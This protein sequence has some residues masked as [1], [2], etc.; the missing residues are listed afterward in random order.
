MHSTLI[1]LALTLIAS[2]SPGEPPAS[3]PATLTEARAAIKSEIQDRAPKGDGSKPDAPPKGVFDLI[4]Y[5]SPAGDLAAYLSPDPKDGKKHPAIIVCTGGFGG[6][7]SSSWTVER[8]T[9]HFRKAGLIVMCPSWRGQQSNPGR[10][11]CFRGEIDDALAALEHLRALPYVDTSRIYITGHSTGGTVSLMVAE[12]TDKVRA[13]FPLGARYDARELVQKDE[14]WDMPAPFDVNNAEELRIRSPINFI[15][16]IQASTFAFEGKRSPNDVDAPKANQLAK[17]AGK[18]FTAFS[19]TSGDHFNIVD[20]INAL[21]AAKIAADTGPA[22]SIAFSDEEVQRAFATRRMPYTPR[23]NLDPKA[24]YLRMT[25]AAVEEIASAMKE[26]K[27]DP[28]KVYVRFGM[29]GYF[30]YHI[31][32]DEEVDPR[33]LTIDMKQFKVLLDPLSAF[34]MR[35]TAISYSKDG[36]FDYENP[37]EN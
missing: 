17:A 27:H 9:G 6:I 15:A 2:A 5:K 24:P 12:C 37:N 31:S 25:N 11:E 33:D 18:P 32:F 29:D 26:R 19:I 14:I 22:L 16:T 3:S 30:S 13:A 35:G 4:N 36:G 7:G 8:Y 28:A 1:A 34:L 21:I 20:P 10:W 23:A